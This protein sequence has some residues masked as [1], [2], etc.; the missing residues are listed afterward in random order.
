VKVDTL[1]VGPFIFTDLLALVL[2]MN[3][4]THRCDR[5]VGN[6]GSNLLRFMVVQFDVQQQRIS[7]TDSPDLL[8]KN[9]KVL[10]SPAK[11]NQQSDFEFP[12]TINES[13][14]D[15]IQ[16]DSGDG[17]LFE[18]S[19]APKRQVATK[20]PKQKIRDGIGVTSVGSVGIPPKAPQQVFLSNIQFGGSYINKGY[21][22]TTQAK[23]S[24]MGRYLFNYGVLTLDYIHKQYAF[25]KYPKPI[26]PPRYDFG[27]A[28]ITSGHKV[29]AGMVWEDSEA[30]RKGM[31]SGDEIISMER[32]LFKDLPLC[33]VETF[34]KKDRPQMEIEVV[35]IDNVGNKKKVRLPKFMFM[36]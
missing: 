21:L 11:L 29:M 32:V 2:N 34:A 18:I 6:F 1:K 5:F 20:F 3:N 36:N 4:S 31:R 16:F 33:Q 26:L 17:N 35:F 12:V 15:T 22:K 30:Y 14:K 9:V 24:R 27:F 25:E 7:I 23:R 13:V 19:E 8:T 10:F 28:P